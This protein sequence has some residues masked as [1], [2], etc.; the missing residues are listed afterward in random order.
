[1]S[2]PDVT[3]INTATG[4]GGD[5]VTMRDTEAG[6]RAPAIDG[7]KKAPSFRSK[8]SVGKESLSSRQSNERS[9]RPLDPLLYMASFLP[10]CNLLCCLL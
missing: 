6:E 4:R 10:C 1:M 3:R 2:T 5:H 8:G 9:W 7:D